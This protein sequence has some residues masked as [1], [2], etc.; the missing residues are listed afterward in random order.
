MGVAMWETIGGLEC[1]GAAT[2]MSGRSAAFHIGSRLPPVSVDMLRL[3]PP[4]STPQTHRVVWG[5]S[6]C[7][8]EV[9]KCV[10]AQYWL[11]TVLH[12]H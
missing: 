1:E 10:N 3:L 6:Q 7:V 4:S 11:A 9:C 2:V 5:A 8:Y 12:A